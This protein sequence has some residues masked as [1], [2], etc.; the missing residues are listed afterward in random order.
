MI[1][2]PFNLHVLN[3][4][5]LQVP[6]NEASQAGLLNLPSM[7]L[8]LQHVNSFCGSGLAYYKNQTVTPQEPKCGLP[9]YL[10]KKERADIKKT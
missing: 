5:N 2:F 8:V 1:Q 9:I 7:K 4:H 3:G 10:N 6:K